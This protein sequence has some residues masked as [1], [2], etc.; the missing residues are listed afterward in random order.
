MAGGLLL[1]FWS[2]VQNTV[3]DAEPVLFVPSIVKKIEAV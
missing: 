1:P 2:L 3:E